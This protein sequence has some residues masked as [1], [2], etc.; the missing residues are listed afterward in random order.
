VI[1]QGILGALERRLYAAERG[2]RRLERLRARAQ[3]AF[4]EQQA[5]PRCIA[6][7]F[8]LGEPLARLRRRRAGRI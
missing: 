3:L 1:D 8:G 2:T 6:L 5:L 7:V 4:V